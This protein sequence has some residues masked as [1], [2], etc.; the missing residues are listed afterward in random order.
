VSELFNTLTG[1]SRQRLYRKLLVAPVNLREQLIALI[2]REAA[3]AR[4]GFPARIVAKMN[5]LVDGEVIDALCDASRA[6]VEMDLIVRGICCLRPGVAGESERIRVTSIIGR[7]LEHSRLWRFE[8]GGEPEY[9]IGFADWMPRNLDR[10]VEAMVPILD[11]SLHPRIESLLDVFL[12]DNRQAWDLDADGTW[13]Q[14]HAGDEE[15]RAT[16]KRLLRDSW[17]MARAP[18]VSAEPASV[19]AIG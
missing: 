11:K 8:N 18:R 1:F 12:T 13:T 19:V 5:S 2:A 9:Y 3:N 14:R 10:R 15:E 7:F 17:G 16:H 6:G 4:A